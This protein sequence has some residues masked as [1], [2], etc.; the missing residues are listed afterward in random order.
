MSY[1]DVCRKLALTKV[2]NASLKTTTTKEEQFKEETSKEETK[3]ITTPK[4]EQIVTNNESETELTKRLA[5]KFSCYFTW[6]LIKNDKYCLELLD[7]LAYGRDDCTYDSQILL[8]AFDSYFYFL[9]YGKKEDY[10]E[11][12]LREL[13]KQNIQI[14]KEHIYCVYMLLGQVDHIKAFILTVDWYKLYLRIK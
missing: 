13:Y 14:I 7:S 1:A 5:K 12:H 9:K 2:V 11:Y 4:H 3:L 8:E 6:D 10:E